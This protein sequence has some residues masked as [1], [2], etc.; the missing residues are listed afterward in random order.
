GHLAASYLAAAL[1]AGQIQCL[2]CD[3]ANGVCELV[4]AVFWADH[5]L[6]HSGRVIFRALD[7]VSGGR[8]GRVVFVRDRVFYVWQPD[9][10]KCW[11]ALFGK[12]AKPVGGAPSKLTP[13][14][15]TAGIKLL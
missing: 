15:I 13:D 12:P 10:A 14:E 5:T 1:K 2:R 8:G 6:Y 7:H 11:P 9:L 4:A 3:I